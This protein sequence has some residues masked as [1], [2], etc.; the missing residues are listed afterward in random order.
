MSTPYVGN[1]IPAPGY[2]RKGTT[3][4]PELLMASNPGSYHQ[5]GV[6]LESGQGVLLLGTLLKQNPATKKYVRATDNTAEGI[7]RTTVD[8]GSSPSGQTWMGN[9]LYSGILNL[10]LVSTANSTVSLASITGAK[11][12]AVQNFFKF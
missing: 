1:A 7:L 8:T 5:K 6:T 12:N 11:I 3:T 4:D 10:A 2:N 9:I